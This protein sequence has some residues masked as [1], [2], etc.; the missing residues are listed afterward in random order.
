MSE[1]LIQTFFVDGILEK[2]LD[3]FFILGIAF[4]ILYLR[5]FNRPLKQLQ[6]IASHSISPKLEDF[7]QE[8]MMEILGAFSSRHYLVLLKNKSLNVSIIEKIRIILGLTK[9]QKHFFLLIYE[10][11][12]SYIVIHNQK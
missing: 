11:L 4:R 12:I 7:F 1:W 3:S 8:S 5:F 6:L 9:S 10:K 2:S